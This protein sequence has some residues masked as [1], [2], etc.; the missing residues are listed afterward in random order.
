MNDQFV[1]LN[2][3]RK[4]KELGFDDGCF[5]YIHDA[6]DFYQ[7]KFSDNFKKCNNS[8][9]AS[10][11]HHGYITLPTWQQ[12]KKWLWDKHRIWAWAEHWHPDGFIWLWKE[13]RSEVNMNHKEKFD[14][15]YMAEIEGIK[16]AVEFLHKQINK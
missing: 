12:L 10:K 8:E 16:Q 6:P 7:Y 11:I 2:I 4:L 3:A 15:P 13:G 14:I 5:K 9:L 1:D